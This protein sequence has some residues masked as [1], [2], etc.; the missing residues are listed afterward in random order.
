MEAMDALR[1]EKDELKA[2]CVQLKEQLDT[3]NCTAT[4]VQEENERLMAQVED[5][6][7]AASATEALQQS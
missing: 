7:T 3:S 4:A 5:L 2:V 1:L 6:Q